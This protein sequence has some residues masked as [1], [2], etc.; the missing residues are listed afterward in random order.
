MREIDIQDDDGGVLAYVVTHKEDYYKSFIKNTILDETISNKII[1]FFERNREDL[2]VFKDLNVKEEKRGQGLGEFYLKGTMFAAKTPLTIS[3][4]EERGN[5]KKGF[6]V[7]KF[8]KTNGF[9]KVADTVLGPL[10]LYPQHKAKELR[11]FMA[12]EG[13]DISDDVAE[14]KKKNKVSFFMNP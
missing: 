6:S 2:L 1:E 9:E 11:L 10:M 14:E 7:E 5:Q 12:L 8:Y 3:I 4:A 13:V